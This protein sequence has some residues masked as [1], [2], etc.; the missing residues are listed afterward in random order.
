MP[1][2]TYM[3]SIFM[4]RDIEAM[5]VA[6]LNQEKLNFTGMSWGT[7]LATTYLENFPK[8]V[9]AMTLDSVL[10]QTVLPFEFLLQ[11]RKAAQTASDRF[12]KWCKVNETCPL[13]EEVDTRD[14]AIRAFDLAGD[15]ATCLSTYM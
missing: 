10:D 8:T 11:G 13:H 15:D 14:I 1:L 9:G 7:Q 5:R 2:V 3:D 4:A 12:S 6:L